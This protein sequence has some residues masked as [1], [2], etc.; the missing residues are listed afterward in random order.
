MSPPDDLTSI[1]RADLEAL[2]IRLFG[3]LTEF[4]RLVAEQRD[5]IARLKGEKGRP[6]F[7]PSGMEGG[8]EPKPT[9]KGK[10]HRGRGKSAPRASIEER[11]EERVVKTNVPPGSRLKGHES[12]V[13]RDLVLRAQVIRYRRERWVTPDGRTV[14]AP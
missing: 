2:V 13:A 14:V 7:K 10:Q 1:A 6:T 3:E 12:F 11:I 5:E 8:T 9:R 4:K